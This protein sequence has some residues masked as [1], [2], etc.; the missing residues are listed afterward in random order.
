[1]SEY[2]I[3]YELDVNNE[4]VIKKTFYGYEGFDEYL[5]KPIN[6]VELD[7]ILREQLHIGEGE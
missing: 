2:A 3:A 7:D 1:M 6:Q 4:K 5:S